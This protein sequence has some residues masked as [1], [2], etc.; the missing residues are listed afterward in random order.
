[1]KVAA[2]MISLAAGGDAGGAG[3]GEE[4][5]QHS[6]ATTFGAVSAGGT[7]IFHARADVGCLGD[8]VA[9][10]AGMLQDKARLAELEVQHIFACDAM[11]G[12]G[13]CAKPMLAVLCVVISV[14]ARACCNIPT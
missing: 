4:E 7:V 12:Q 5:Q 8:C 13:R 9:D 10:L 2:A 1:M 11:Q 6:T 3:G 14:L